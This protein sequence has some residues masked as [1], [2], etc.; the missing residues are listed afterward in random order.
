M[1]SDY[2]LSSNFL[3]QD[4]HPSKSS[5]KAFVE[6]IK[7]LQRLESLKISN[8]KNKAVKTTFQLLVFQKL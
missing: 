4:F 3:V 7:N 8:K 1:L 5:S 6:K 2:E